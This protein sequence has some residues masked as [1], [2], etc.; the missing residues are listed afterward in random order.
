MTNTNP[1]SIIEEAGLSQGE[2]AALCQVT[3]CTVNLWVNGKM[4]P[5]RYLLPQIETVSA[6]LR[7][8]VEAGALPLKAPSRGERRRQAVTEAIQSVNA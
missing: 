1:F 4:K 5:H 3:R 8:A 6:R 7:K 2:F